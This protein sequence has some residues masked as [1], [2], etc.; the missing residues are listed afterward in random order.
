MVHNV[1]RRFERSPLTEAEK[2]IHGDVD[3]AS[4]LTVAKNAMN[5]LNELVPDGNADMTEEQFAQLISGVKELGTFLRA[6]GCH[7]AVLHTD[8]DVEGL[9]AEAILAGQVVLANR[10][11]PL[12]ANL[13]GA[14]EG[15]P[16]LEDAKAA[17][18]AV[19]AAVADAKA[20][21]EPQAAAENS[22][23]ATTE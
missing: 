17:V 18:D 15:S 4:G 3:Y 23:P 5:Q 19:F 16:A 6:R 7:V 12:I 22:E 2:K 13:K 1:K 8:V 11:E 9:V 21:D 10:V 20:K 14:G